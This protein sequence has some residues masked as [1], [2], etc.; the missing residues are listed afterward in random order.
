MRR[1]GGSA[2]T[3]SSSS[4]RASACARAAPRPKR[5]NTAPRGRPAKSPTVRSPS[6]PSSSRSLS[7]SGRTSSGSGVRYS[8]ASVTRRVSPG[9]VRSAATR[10]AN[11][12]SATPTDAC[13]PMRSRRSM[14][15]RAMRE[16]APRTRSVPARSQANVPV[17]TTPTCG[18]SARSVMSARACS[19]SVASRTTTAAINSRAP[20]AQRACRDRSRPRRAR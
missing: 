6:R 2:C 9:P 3:R 18:S 10:A 12:V 7:S 20:R 13:A 8:R 4:A 19:V 16:G 1:G 17:A 14:I 11:G 5:S 15:R